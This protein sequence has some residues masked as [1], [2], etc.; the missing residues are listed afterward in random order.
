MAENC[1]KRATES[2][3]QK[4]ASGRSVIDEAKSRAL[5]T[6]LV[7]D[8]LC[9]IEA[10]TALHFATVAGIGR[11]CSSGTGTRCLP[12]FTLRDAVADADDHGDRYNR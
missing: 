6:F 9:I 12:D 8:F 5:C 10:A 2:Q 11:L 3:S 7:E 1:G 4:D